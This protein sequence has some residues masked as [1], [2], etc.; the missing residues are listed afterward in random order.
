MWIDTID[1]REFLP[2]GN[3]SPVVSNSVLTVFVID[4]VIIKTNDKPVEKFVP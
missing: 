4:M 1:R 3:T 2:E